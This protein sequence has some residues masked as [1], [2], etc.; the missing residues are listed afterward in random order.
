[1]AT[2]DYSFERVED[3][4]PSRC[5][6]VIGTIGQCKIKAVEG[7]KYC[8]NHGG[9]EKDNIKAAEISN[10]QLAKYQ[11]RLERMKANPS[12]KSLR[13]EVVILRMMLETRLNACETDTDLLL[14]S[15]PISELVVKIEKLVSS[16]HKLEGSMGRL[17]DKSAILQFAS[18]VI[19]IISKHIKEE[20]TLELIADEILQ[21]VSRSGESNDRQ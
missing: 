17:L 16:C 20:N 19:T 4:D 8:P 21:S 10:Y 5:Q 2:G 15:G 9:N 18:E 3:D 13:D 6:A 11:A 7:S 14:H 1:M 12:I